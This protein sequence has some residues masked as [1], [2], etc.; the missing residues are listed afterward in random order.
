[1]IKEKT[2]P[3]ADKTGWEILTEAE[4]ATL[5]LEGLGDML[6][7]LIEYY[8]LS[9]REL[10]DYQKRFLGESSNTIYNI[11]RLVQAGLYSANERIEAIKLKKDLDQED[12]ETAK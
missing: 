11:L 3:K 8:N 12:T 7:I 5:D 1:M 2:R 9:N 10:T 6:G 4:E